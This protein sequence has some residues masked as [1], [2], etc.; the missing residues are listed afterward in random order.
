MWVRR[1]RQAAAKDDDNSEDPSRRTK[2]TAGGVEDEQAKIDKRRVLEITRAWEFSIFGLL[3]KRLNNLAN[4][5]ICLAFNAEK[6]DNILL[7]SKVLTYTKQTGIRGVSIHREGSSIR[8]LLFDNIRIG[9]IRRLTPLSDLSGLA[10]MCNL[11]ETK[12]IFP[13]SKL[14]TFDYLREPR[15]PADK[16]DWVSSLNPDRAP[17]QQ[18]VDSALEFFD[19]KGFTCVLDYLKFYLRLDVIILQRALKAIGRK[20]FQILGLHYIDSRKFTASSFS[21][22]GAQTF[23]AR[24]RRPGSWFVNHA[25]TYAVCTLCAPHTHTHTHTENLF[26]FRCSCSN[27]VYA[28]SVCF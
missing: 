15:L 22:A 13:F 6:F 25:R 23:L 7:A 10:K 9:E 8:H 24:H 14:T 26:P 2:C 3:Q 18:E 19:R 11:R 12:C 21:A 4:S 28:V 27:L 1:R 17:S 5:F 20:Y 16:S